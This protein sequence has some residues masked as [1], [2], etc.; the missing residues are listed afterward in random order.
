MGEIVGVRR[1]SSTVEREAAELL[2]A[3]IPIDL[4]IIAAQEYVNDCL[5]LLALL[6][7]DSALL[8][9]KVR[10]SLVAALAQ[11]EPEAAKP[12]T[13]EVRALADEIGGD[14]A[15]AY[16]LLAWALT[17]PDPK[18][19]RKRIEAAYTVLDTASVH[20]EELLVAPG[21]CVLLVGL[22]E[23]GE[24]RSLDSELLRRRFAF[25]HS[26]PS[27]MPVPLTWFACL[28][29]ILDGDTDRAEAQARDLF[30]S[31]PHDGTNALGLYATH[32]SLIRWMQGRTDKIEEE[33]LTARREYPHQLLWTALVAWL[34]LLQGRQ[35]SAEALLRT[36]PQL[37]ELPRNGYWLA[38][39]SVIA[40][41][42]RL[43][44]TKNQIMGIRQML[45]PYASHLVPVGVGLAFWGTVARTLGLLNEHLGFLA[46]A[47]EHLELAIT[48]TADV[49]ALAWHAEAQIELAEF[50]LRHGET[51]IPAYELLAEA[52]ATCESRGFTRL[53]HRAMYRPRIRVFGGFDVVSVCGQ[54]AEW[55]SRK[56]RELL[57]MLVAARGSSTSR[58]VFMHYLWPDEDPELL[59]NRFA[60]AVNVIRRALDPKR[61]Q[62]TQHYVQTVGDSVRL[63]IG[64]LDIDLER[65]Y[66]LAG[67]HE[68]EKRQSAA[69]LYTGD[70]FSDEPY[71]DWAISIRE[72][73]RFLRDQLG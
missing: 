3:G 70:L 16:A 22:L 11:I 50:A 35:S 20:R 73:T 9:L 44:G 49:G 41:I 17:H 31:A 14:L 36:F 56:A 61:L 42:A 62:P 39:L 30:E 53:A 58:E 60:V 24:I 52:K 33:L 67:S 12:V 5:K 19:T 69:R 51:D 21:Y 46:E 15:E 7:P 43:I 23:A 2:D 32:V 37:T 34:W 6:G 26:D 64:N 68:S 27:R 45:L 29:T 65:F 63:N 71:A 4:T 57:K 1:D 47:R 13:A 48:R 40:E 10:T 38:T 72:R 55:T 66:A 59:G 25:S 8:T 54:E 18:H 28:R